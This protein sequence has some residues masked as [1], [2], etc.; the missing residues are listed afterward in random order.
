M[1]KFS[2]FKRH[3]ISDLDAETNN[4]RS[5]QGVLNRAMAVIRHQQIIELQWKQLAI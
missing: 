5:A 3:I 1:D 4:A 2:K